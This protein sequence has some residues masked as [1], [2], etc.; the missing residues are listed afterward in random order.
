MLYKTLQAARKIEVVKHDVC[1]E[2]LCLL[3][4]QLQVLCAGLCLRCTIECLTQGQ[5]STVEGPQSCQTEKSR[6]DMGALTSPDKKS[7]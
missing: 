7:S 4:A 6:V 5:C 3:F 1:R 2:T